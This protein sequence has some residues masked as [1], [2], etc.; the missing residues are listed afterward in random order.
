[1]ELAYGYSQCRAVLDVAL[2]LLAAQ[3]LCRQ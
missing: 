3:G 1:M 2:D